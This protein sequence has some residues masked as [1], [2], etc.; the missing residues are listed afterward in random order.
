MESRTVV[1]TSGQNDVTSVTLEIIPDS[2]YVVAARDFTAGTNPDAAKIQSITLSDSETTGGPQNDGSY[3]ASNKVNVVVDFVDSYAPTEN[4]TLDID[5]SGSATP[6]NLIPVKLQGAFAVPG[7]PDKV[8]F[9][10]S[11]VEDFASSASTTDF[12]AYE[13]PGDLVTIMV[14]TIAATSNDFINE[15]PT[16]SISNTSNA[17]AEDDYDIA[18][19]DTFDSE[20]RLTQVVYTVK[21][22]IPKLSRSSDLITFTGAGA[23]IPGLDNKIYGFNMNTEKADSRTINRRLEINADS[24]SKFRIKMQRGTLSGNPEVFTADATYGTY[25]FD[26]TNL[27]IESAFKSSSSSVTFPSEIDSNGDYIASTDPFTVDSSGLFYKDIVIPPDTTSKVY[28]FTITPQDSTI[29]DADA[30]GIDTLPDPDVITF[31]IKRSAE[32]YI[33]GTYNSALLRTSLTDAT[34]YYN[35]QNISKGTNKPVGQAESEVNSQTNTYDYEIVITDDVDFHLPN[36]ENVFTLTDLNYTKTL[37]SGLIE[38]P[39]ITAE[40]RA[41]SNGFN[42]S[43]IQS[44]D[45][46]ASHALAEAG[47]EPNTTVALTELQREALTNKT[48]FSLSNLSSDITIVGD[49][50]FLKIKFF[51]TDETPVYK[52]QTI[53]IFSD[54]QVQGGETGQQNTTTI[55]SP[56]VDRSKLYITAEDLSISKWGD[57]N[58]SIRTD[59]DTFAFTSSQTVNTLNLSLGITQGVRKFVN[60]LVG[61]VGYVYN[62]D[63]Y[64]EKEVFN[65]GDADFKKQN[66]TQNTE[67]VRYTISGAFLVAQDGLP[68]GFDVND[69]ELIFEP[70]TFSSVFSGVTVSV[71]TQPSLSLDYQNTNDRTLSMTDFVVI[72]DFSSTLSSLS[73]S[74]NYFYNTNIVHKLS[75]NYKD[76]GDIEAEYYLD[77][78]TPQPATY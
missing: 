62:E 5:P 16:I 49:S 46:Y 31:D 57:N 9:T 33:E 7:T 54:Y 6:D 73:T 68:S 23:D 19:V 14:M 29:I 58:M 21:A 3:T 12:Y 39:V 10:A 42:A 41:N 36:Q 67:Q 13:N 56:A 37:N 25:V 60:D 76:I 53:E 71:D 44:G 45:L 22:T 65:A 34:E 55:S 2:G 30:I 28:R 51:T 77:T 74:Q 72:I 11:S 1:T 70:S 24:G 26:N 78:P 59:L 35:Y 47:T 18:R 15:D 61:S 63:Y 20:N 48:S 4:I 43:E 27:T 32:I 66:I 69:Y 8:T 64:L 40:I 50:Q 75:N 38:D 17:T 52:S